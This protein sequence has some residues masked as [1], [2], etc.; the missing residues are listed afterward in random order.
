MRSRM[1]RAVPVLRDSI[2]KLG[3]RPGEKIIFQLGCDASPIPALPEYDEDLDIVCGTCGPLGH[4]KC[5]L[6]HPGAVGDGEEG[7][8]AIVK[9]VLEREWASYLYIGILQPMADRVPNQTVLIYPTC[10]RYDHTPHL[11][12]FWKKI[13]KL[14]YEILVLMAGLPVMLEGKGADGDMRERCSSMQRIYLRYMHRFHPRRSS[15]GEMVVNFRSWVGLENATGFRLF[16]VKHVLQIRDAN[17]NQKQMIVVSGVDSSDPA[18]CDKKIDRSGQDKSKTHVIGGYEILHSHLLTVM[19]LE[20]T[21]QAI[22]RVATGNCESI[23][24]YRSDLIGQDPQNW[25]ACV[26]RCGFMMLRALIMLQPNG[27]SCMRGAH[28]SKMN[29]ACLPNHNM[30]PTTMPVLDAVLKGRHDK[31]WV[32]STDDLPE[33]QTQGTVAFYAM[34]ATL[35]IL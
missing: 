6:H 19:N 23:G 20:K 26:R 14:F 22:G 28:P 32:C 21:V 11:E 10:N 9:T 24:V 1:L 13:Y 7:Y 35:L 8:N 12:F 30:D 25:V 5:S 3:L 17:N 15:F 27:P 2:A 34:A 18:H 33:L 4:Q 29:R 16:G 31:P